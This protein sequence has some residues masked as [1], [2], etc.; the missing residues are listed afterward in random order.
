LSHFIKHIFFDLD[1]TIWDFDRNAQETLLELYEA[2]QLKALGLNSVDFIERYTANNHS[3]WQQY[4]LG[5]IT[6][7][8]LRQDR[9][10]NTFLELGVKP[11]LIPIEFEEDY[12]RISP[13]K[14]NLFEGAEK[15]LTYLQNK[16]DLH[17]ISNGFKETT[18][19]K[20]DLCGLNPYFTNVIISEDVGINKPDRL[21]F[22]H[23]ITKADAKVEESIMI[24]DSL[25]ADIRGAQNFG[26]KAIF[27]NPLNI[28][29]PE[30][31]EWQ[32]SHLEELL[33]HF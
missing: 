21:I 13:T 26:M 23:A 10:R 15:V 30:D 31:V 7:E 4:H 28:A 11:E 6:K 5:E 3:L 22:E 14:T 2:Y 16:Y 33:H 20:M 29:Q 19:T 18:L 27:F 32:I 17:I 9:F 24:G 1:H 25:E 12:V 8:K